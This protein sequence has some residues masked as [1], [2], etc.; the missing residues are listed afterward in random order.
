MGLIYWNIGFVKIHWQGQIKLFKGNKV[1]YQ[2]G[3]NLFDICSWEREIFYSQKLE[4]W[5]G[6]ETPLIQV[7]NYGLL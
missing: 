4:V 5:Q 3:L 7:I 1:Y 6:L 2:F